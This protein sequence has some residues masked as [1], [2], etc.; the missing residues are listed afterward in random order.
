MI[1]PGFMYYLQKSPGSVS[2]FFLVLAKW[3][4]YHTRRSLWQV[5][6][7]SWTP[8]CKI[9][10]PFTP[11]YF[12]KRTLLKNINSVIS[13]RVFTDICVFHFS[14][15]VSVDPQ[16]SSLV[17]YTSKHGVAHN[18]IL[19]SQHFN[20]SLLSLSLSVFFFF[21]FMF[22]YNMFHYKVILHVQVVIW[23]SGCTFDQ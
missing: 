6:L 12:V 13:V 16:K 1:F 15:L 19:H 7:P 3:S 21:K 14:I 22:I 9:H 8:F 5:C 23:F 17:W 18:L 10:T 4:I 20:F 11:I 2:Y